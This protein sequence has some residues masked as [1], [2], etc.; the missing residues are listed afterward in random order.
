MASHEHTRGMLPYG[1]IPHLLSQ[2]IDLTTG[3]IRAF[4][5]SNRRIA[6]SSL[7]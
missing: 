4:G 5:G 6:K 7:A 1:T 2:H 3:R